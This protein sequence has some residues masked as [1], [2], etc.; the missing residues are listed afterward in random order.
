MTKYL[1][2]L[3]VYT[4]TFYGF[5]ILSKFVQSQCLISDTFTQWLLMLGQ[6]IYQQHLGSWKFSMSVK[7]LNIKIT[8]VCIHFSHYANPPK[9][10]VDTADIPKKHLMSFISI[11]LVNYLLKSDL[12]KH[13]VLT[14]EFVRNFVARYWYKMVA[15][16]CSRHGL[17]LFKVIVQ[18]SKNFDHFFLTCTKKCDGRDFSYA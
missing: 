13:S 12:K 3:D 7:K 8:F 17:W 11:S 14:C 4:A 2:P 10:I 5:H 16:H 15:T 9:C 1:L 18:V 6:N